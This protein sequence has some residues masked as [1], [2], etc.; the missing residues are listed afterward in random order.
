VCDTGNY[1]IRKIS[2]QGKVPLHLLLFS[3]AYCFPLLLFSGVASTIAGSGAK[4]M[5]DGQGINVSFSNLWGIDFD[6]KD[7]SFY[8][9]DYP[10][11]RKITPQGIALSLMQCNDYLLQEL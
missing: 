1:R 4:G 7:G 10:K 3:S 8:A 11:I 6:Q 9:A 5:V 2:L